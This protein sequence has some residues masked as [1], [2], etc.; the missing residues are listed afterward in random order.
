MDD[1]NEVVEAME[2]SVKSTPYDHLKRVIFLLNL[3]NALLSRFE[4]TGSMDNLNAAVEKI[5]ELVKLTPHND[6]NQGIYLN[7]LQ[8]KKSETCL[9]VTIYNYLLNSFPKS[10]ALLEQDYYS[11]ILVKK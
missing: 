2:E 11:Y 9:F 1:L 6:I 3:S 4:R 5:E 10:R 7:N 8:I